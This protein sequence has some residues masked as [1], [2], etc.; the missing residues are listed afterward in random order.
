MLADDLT[1]PL[2]LHLPPASQLTFHAAVGAPVDAA[3]AATATVTA[4]LIIDATLSG[5]EIRGSVNLPGALL[6]VPSRSTSFVLNLYQKSKGGAKWISQDWPL[7]RAPALRRRRL[8]AGTPPPRVANSSLP[9]ASSHPCH[10]TRPPSL[11]PPSPPPSKAPP[12]LRPPSYLID[13]ATN[14][15]SSIL[16]RCSGEA[17][18][19]RS[20]P[21]LLTASERRRGRVLVCPRFP[22]TSRTSSEAKGASCGTI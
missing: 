22:K 2:L 18:S 9:A 4:R 5:S 14:A 6:R 1:L 16:C 8:P 7:F 13:A 3:A 15:T 20:P 17:P 11:L 10:M 12:A 21:A 19:P